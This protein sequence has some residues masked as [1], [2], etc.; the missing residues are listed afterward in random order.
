[1]IDYAAKEY[2]EFVKQLETDP[3]FCIKYIATIDK[4]N[5]TFALCEKTISQDP[6][7]ALNYADNMKRRFV[8]G[9]EAI[10]TDAKTAFLYAK[11]IIK[12]RF[13]MG[14]KAI[15]QDSVFAYKYAL[16]IIRGRWEVGEEAISKDSKVLLAY[17]KEVIKGKL[18]EEL[19]NVMIAKRI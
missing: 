17:A 2:F 6:M 1:M 10:A 8:L 7:C 11:D 18:P 15:S 14:E 5:P 19:H 4:S 16:F 13:E 9:E 12:G 3:F